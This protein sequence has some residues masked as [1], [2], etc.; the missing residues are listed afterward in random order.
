[1]N[2]CDSTSFSLGTIAVVLCL[3]ACNVHNEY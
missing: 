3:C 1:V 2:K